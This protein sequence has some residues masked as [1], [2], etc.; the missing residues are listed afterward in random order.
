MKPNRRDI[1]AMGA[2][3][4]LCL[5]FFA[6]TFFPSNENEIILGEDLFWLFRPMGEFAFENFR[7]GALPLWNPYLFLGFPQY[8]EPQLSTFYPP[9]WLAAWVPIESSFSFLY[10]FHFALTAIG[11]YLLV[12]QLGGRW[13]G[14]L[15]AGIVLTFNGFMIA[16]LHAGHVPHLMTLSYLPLL[17]AA[18]HWAVQR[19]S[20]AATLL[21]GVPL[22]LAML[23]GY[24]PFFP[25]LVAAVSLLMLWLAVQE[26][27][28]REYAKG[29]WIL[30]QLVILGLFSGMLA[31]VQLLPTVEMTLASSRVAGAD[32]AFANSLSMPPWNYLTLLL[33]GLYGDPVGDILYWGAAPIN[34]F[35]EYAIYAGILPFILF[36]L[37][38]P[39][40]Q[41]SWRF[42]FVFGL[43]GLILASGS[44]LA[45]HRILY[46]LVPGF[47]LFRVPARMG[48]F[49]VLAAAVI[50]GLLFDHWLDLS[51][52]EREKWIPRLRQA[53][54]RGLG[55]LSV[56]VV[57]SVLWQAVQTNEDEI[58]AQIG[59]ITSQL[60]RLM[61]LGGGAI[62]LLIG[63]KARPRWQIAM[64]AVVLLVID[65]WGNSYQFITLEDATP[66]VGWVMADLSLPSNRLEY[67]ILSK[68]LAENS[69]ILYDF[70]HVDGYDD[71]RTKTGLE[72]RDRAFDDARIARLLG[73]Q[74]LLHGFRYEKEPIA[75]GWELIAQPAG[76]KIYERID[77]QSRAFIVYDVI[78]AENEAHSLHLIDDPALDFTR[79]AVVEVVPNTSCA[80]ETPPA[81]AD[82]QVEIL[83]YNP[84]QVVLKTD[85]PT[86]GWLV[87]SDLYYPGWTAAVS[88]SPAAIQPTNYGLRGV[89]VPAGTHEIVFDFEPDILNY[90]VAVTGAALIVLLI[91]VVYL[92]WANRTSHRQ[93]I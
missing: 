19:R 85:T 60:I 13:S 32:Y 90:G 93:A 70:Y 48:Y 52:S 1:I 24:A 16:R 25:F 58:S 37:V 50:T 76:V 21:A 2:L 18:A 29:A 75:P 83:A 7:Q 45:I 14:A 12:R 67:R 15:L 74:Y 84:R 86:T 8:A 71:F 65:L 82:A 33:P 31:A 5:F 49:F 44:A 73:T 36:I 92:I 56:L 27:Q 41:R 40:G 81:G 23:A 59:G 26:W 88:G 80:I 55:L 79:T 4:C 57:M 34:A 6:G 22:G 47:G 42:W 62:L 72:L 66:E 17:L 91:A 30:A 10:A 11:G 77:A 69:G 35:W 61:L 51:N 53:L 54:W 28:K 89:C 9:M 63:A 3:V 39:L 78:A 64:L 20:I 87:L 38:W 46:H 68:G 43:G